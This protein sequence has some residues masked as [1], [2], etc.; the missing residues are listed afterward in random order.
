M[1]GTGL[2]ARQGSIDRTPE[3]HKEAAEAAYLSDPEGLFHR[4]Y[5]QRSFMFPHG[6]SGNASFEL[7]SLIELARRLPQTDEFVYWSNGPVGVTS[8]WEDGNAEKHSLEDTIRHIADNNSMVILKHVEQDP[9]V[10]PILKAFLQQ[11]VDLAD[12]GMLDDVIV[13]EALILIAS[14]NRVTSY[15]IDAECNYLVQLTGDK[16]LNVFDPADRSLI[17]DEELERFHGGDYNGASYKPDRQHEA[18]VYDLRAGHGVHIPVGAPHWVRNG[19]N[20][21]V[22]LSINY[23]LRSVHEQS[24]IYKINRRLRRL[25]SAPIAPGVSPWRDKLKLAVARVVIGREQPVRSS[26]G[27]WAPGPR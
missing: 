9:Q 10:G 7:P 15:H 26:Q 3:S 1:H 27:T 11:V 14:P 4:H 23:E 22:A 20:V 19:D 25:G 13:G 24:R 21:S 8:R 2:A 16:T 12:P 18:Q 5:N 6:L 17:T